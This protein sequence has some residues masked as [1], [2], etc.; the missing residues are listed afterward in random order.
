[1]KL[2]DLPV[3]I[4]QKCNNRCIF[5]SSKSEKGSLNII[6]YSKLE[7]IIDFAHQCNVEEFSLSG[8]E[9]LLHPDIFAILNRCNEYRLPVRIYTSGNYSKSSLDNLLSNLETLINPNITFIFSY[10]STNIE[11]FCY[12]NG[13]TNSEM[14]IITE[15][16]KACIKSDYKTE[17]HIVPNNINVANIAITCK[18][19]KELG[20]EQVSLLNMVFQGRAKDNERELRIK[21]GDYTLDWEFNF[22]KTYICDN[23]FSL[24]SSI[25]EGHVCKAGCLK[26]SIRWDGKVFPC[27]AFKEAPNNGLYTLG[28]IYEDE[29]GDILHNGITCEE[30][31]KLKRLIKTT[32]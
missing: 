10:P 11:Q 21:D 23:T 16:L 6:P 7:E 22:I 14:G 12:L 19:L 13:C 3:E 2:K 32:N 15:N 1:M 28:D 31:I 26:L 9:P 20:V 8:G 18:Y 17:V 5:C 24:R 27:E 29:L 25:N 30:L 4:I